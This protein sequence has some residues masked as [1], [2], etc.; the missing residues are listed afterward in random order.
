MPTL[1]LPF[2]G[3]FFTLVSAAALALGAVLILML[4]RSGG[5]ERRYLGYSFWNDLALTG[6]WVLGLAGGIGVLRLQPW[7]QYLLELFCWALIVLAPLSAASR[8]Y[9]L[10]QPDPDAPPVNWLRALGGVTLVLLPI[11]VICAAAIMTL[12]SPE[13]RQLF[14][15]N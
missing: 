13:A 4:L 5:I 2:I 10:K 3:W 6:I 8:L 15:G 12:R 9:A 7:G 14:S 1:P 11:I